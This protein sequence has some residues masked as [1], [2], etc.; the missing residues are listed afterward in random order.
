MPGG[1][2]SVSMVIVANPFFAAGHRG[3][4]CANFARVKTLWL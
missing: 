1:E 3:G 2:D 4:V